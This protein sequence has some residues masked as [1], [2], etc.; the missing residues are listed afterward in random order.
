MTPAL[1]MSLDAGLAHA[2]EE[3]ITEEPGQKGEKRLSTDSAS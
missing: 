1:S 3:E 2:E